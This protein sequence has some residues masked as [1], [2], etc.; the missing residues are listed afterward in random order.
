MRRNSLGLRLPIVG[1]VRI[2][3]REDVAFVGGVALLAVVGM[4]E[5]P[6]ALVLAIGHELATNRHN[7][8]LHS[9]GEALEAA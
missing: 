5:W 7:Q 9:F 8:L 1:Q 2:P 4:V 3:A 6:V